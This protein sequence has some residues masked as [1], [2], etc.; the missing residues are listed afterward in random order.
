MPRMEPRV[1]RRL[2]NCSATDII[3]VGRN[4]S[5]SKSQLRLEAEGGYRRS[6]NA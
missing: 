4:V 2:E 5:I 3:A 6:S 1:V